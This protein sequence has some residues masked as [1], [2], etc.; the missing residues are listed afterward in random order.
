MER[1]VCENHIYG[2]PGGEETVALFIEAGKRDISKTFFISS[3][4]STT[5][6]V[7]ACVSRHCGKQNVKMPPPKASRWGH[8][9]PLVTPLGTFYYRI[10][11]Q[12]V[13]RNQDVKPKLIISQQKG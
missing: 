11:I 1:N 2:A 8:V 10:T 9:P 3:Y 12:N 13:I 7:I 5:F 6:P 4:F